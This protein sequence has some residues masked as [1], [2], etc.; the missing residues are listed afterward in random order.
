MH[1]TDSHTHTLGQLSNQPNVHDPHDCGN[2]EKARGVTKR[3][4]KTRS[5]SQTQ[6]YPAMKPEIIF[7]TPENT[8]FNGAS[9]MKGHLEGNH[10]CI[11]KPNNPFLF[12]FLVQAR[13]KKAHIEFHKSNEVLKN[14]L[15]GGGGRKGGGPSV[16]H[17]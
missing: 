17:C 13:L 5:S 12:S 4:S 1:T 9:Q 14:N 10:N 16:I 3:T 7:Q 6:N 15:S 2:Q 11:N 8:R